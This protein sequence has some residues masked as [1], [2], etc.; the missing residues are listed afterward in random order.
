ML[1]ESFEEGSD[2]NLFVGL[3]CYLCIFN[4][5]L[6][7]ELLVDQSCQTSGTFSLG[8]KCKHLATC[9]NRDREPQ[10]SR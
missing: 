4:E 10:N 2:K 3:I 7:R 6:F 5:S 9:L 8:N 1:H